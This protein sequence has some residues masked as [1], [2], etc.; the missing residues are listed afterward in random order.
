MIKLS[1]SR[2]TGRESPERGLEVKDGAIVNVLFISEVVDIGFPLASPN[3]SY[4]LLFDPVV[5]NSL[6]ATL[7]SWL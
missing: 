3:V 5:T 2:L 4:F 1:S 6:E 7:I